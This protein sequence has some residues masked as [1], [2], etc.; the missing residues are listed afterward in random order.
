MRRVGGEAAMVGLIYHEE[1]RIHFQRARMLERA[2]RYEEA[3]REYRL[4]LDHDP[5]LCDARRAL[6]LFYR[7]RGLL[8]KAADELRAVLAVHNDFF[9]HLQL[10]EILLDIGQDDAALEHAQCC[11]AMVPDD[12]GVHL[13]AARALLRL[14][15]LGAAHQHVTEALKRDP[16][17]WHARALLGECLLR[18]G[19]LE[20]AS[21]AFAEAR[22]GADTAAARAL[23]DSRLRTVARY[24]VVGALDTLRD[25]LYAE[26]GAIYIGS[27]Q[28]D[29]ASHTVPAEYHLTYPDIGVI[30]LRFDQLMAELGWQF[31]AVAAIDR[32]ARPVAALLAC[33]LGAPLCAPEAAGAYQRLLLTGVGGRHTAPLAMAAARSPEA[34]TFCLGLGDLHRQYALPQ[35]IGVAADGPCS[36]PW[37]SELQ[38]LR[39][40]GVPSAQVDECLERAERQLSEA[41]GLPHDDPALAQIVSY[42][43]HLLVGAT[44]PGTQDQL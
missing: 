2:D 6:A 44:L 28:R 21:A 39:S 14:G 30:L 38:R 31:D 43:Q 15:D 22:C 20:A 36:V 24:G 12:A 33:R 1:A 18:M 19:A 11:L 4:A 13:L 9:T 42:Y 32:T 16:A 8:S 40:G 23:L 41:I 10:S 17:G 35:V 3:I 27:T 7:N 37:E 29:G 25:R 26:H 5:H 34:I